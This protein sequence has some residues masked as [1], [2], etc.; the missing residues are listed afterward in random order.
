LDELE[1]ACLL[2]LATNQALTSRSGTWPVAITR[3]AP[4]RWVFYLHHS[5]FYSTLYKWWDKFASAT[6]YI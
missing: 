5:N 6:I 2:L 3:D 4:I 1:C